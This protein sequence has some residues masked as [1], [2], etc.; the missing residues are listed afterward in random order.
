MKEVNA[1]YSIFRFFNEN[2]YQNCNV[3][4]STT[5][6]LSYLKYL[7]YI[8][9]REAKDQCKEFGDIIESHFGQKSEIDFTEVNEMS[10]IIYNINIINIYCI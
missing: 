9:F 8:L 6:T 7:L 2:P 5:Y 1:N 4:I 10:I 3:N